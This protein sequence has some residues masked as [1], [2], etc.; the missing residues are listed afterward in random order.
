VR[1]Q[2]EG[3]FDD[4]KQSIFDKG[5]EP[6]IE[7]VAEYL[8]KPHKAPKTNRAALKKDEILHEENSDDT[9]EGTP[10]RRSATSNRKGLKT[11]PLH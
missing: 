9:S 11:G 6:L 10:Q 7:A 2:L 3:W 4:L 1:P 8:E 5:T